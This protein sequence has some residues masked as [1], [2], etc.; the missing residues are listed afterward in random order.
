MNRRF[1]TKPDNRFTAILRGNEGAS[2][3]L[4]TIIAIL[5]VTGVIILRT[6]T[7]ALWAS[8]DKQ[9]NQDQAYEMATS[10]GNSLDGIIVGN[11]SLDLSSIAAGDGVIISK[12]SINGLPNA[13]ISANVKPLSKDDDNRVY[14]VTVEANVATATYSYIAQYSGSG[15]NYQRLY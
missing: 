6:T 10:M 13:T 12:T 8:A 14:V 1:K 2:I 11:K 7:S 3:V 4:V 15:T 9:L 5:I